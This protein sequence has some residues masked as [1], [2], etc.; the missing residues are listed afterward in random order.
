MKK[1]YL[2]ISNTFYPDRNSAAQLLEN[3]AS[4]L[5]KKKYQVVVVCARDENIY[6]NISQLNGIKIINIFC[7]NIKNKNIYKRGIGELI[8]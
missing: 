2:I 3:L 4:E 1:K 7:K 8:K 6:K 5:L